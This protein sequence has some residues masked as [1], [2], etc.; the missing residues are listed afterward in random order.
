MGFEL[1]SLPSLSGKS[2]VV[3]GG[4]TGVGYTT[5]LH[6]AAHGARVYMGAR[7]SEKA[8]KAI[9]QIKAEYPIADIRTLLMDHTSLV[10]VVAGAKKLI[11]QE[12]HIDGVVCNAGIMGVPYSRT[13]DGYELQWQ[14]NYIAHWLFVYHL[15]P[16]LQATA[17]AKGPGSVRVVCVS[18]H[19]H[20]TRGGN[21]ILY[22]EAE[23]EAF[24]RYGCYGQSKL[25]NVLHAKSLND[26]FGPDSGADGQI[27]AASLHPG[28]VDTQMNIKNK[29]MASSKLQWIHPVLQ[30]FK[31]MVPWDQGCRASLFVAASPDFTADL[32]GKYLSDSAK[33]YKPS[34]A[35]ENVEERQKLEKWTRET[36]KADGWLD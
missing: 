18:S 5:C 36:M 33:V 7:S 30:F 15:L 31:I 1:S 3:T 4:N 23:R 17:K 35:A 9:A 28:F 32:C 16:T 26:Q 25:A 6:L 11:A 22:E 13:I 34:K 12:E 19:G 21:R 27:W 24:G 14:T 10:T 2:F 8:E 29:E 20:W